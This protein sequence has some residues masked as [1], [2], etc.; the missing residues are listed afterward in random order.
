[1][2]T[3]V[4]AVLALGLAAPM[5]RQSGAL[6][7]Q[8]AVG[9]S[10][11]P[12]F[13]S[14]SPLVLRIEADFDAIS[15]DRGEERRERPARLS[16][17]APDGRATTIAVRLSTR[18]NFRLSRSVCDFP[19]LRLNFRKRDTAGTVF[20]GQDKLKLVAHCQNGRDDYEQY[21]L[22]EYLAYRVYNLFTEASFRVRLARITYVWDGEK[23]DSLTKYGF[24]IEDEDQ[25]AAR[26]HAE[27]LDAAG[28]HGFAV[29][30]EQAA[31]FEVFQYFVGNADWSVSAL[32]NVKLL[33]REGDPFP[34]IVPYDFD[35]SGLVNA[36]Y[37]VPPPALNTYS[38]KE[39]VF[40]GPCRPVYD[41]L[42]VVDAFNLRREEIYE[43]FRR[44]PGL[45]R[46][47]LEESLDYLDEFY[48]CV[49]DDKCLRRELV[50]RCPEG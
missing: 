24:L 15:K 22:K 45:T 5:A 9:D 47:S 40:I 34:V 31:L 12:L 28:V 39:R 42:R 33:T 32:H 11:P 20:A 18:G 10:V 2:V 17:I 37:A 4:V 16:D 13:S 26:N 23:A 46:R 38:V 36:R 1:M 3:F 25:M 7:R 50:R 44:R 14:H 6:A 21:V 27:I 49:N 29:D 19:P 8:D 35:W 48:D 30:D 41:L 43:L